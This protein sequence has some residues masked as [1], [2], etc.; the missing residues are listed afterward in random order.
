M[1]LV[2]KGLTTTDSLLYSLL[3]D[4]KKIGVS[5]LRLVMAV[6]P[7]LAVGLSELTT[8][9]FTVLAHLG[10]FVFHLRV[11]FGFG[12]NILESH[13]GRYLAN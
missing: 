13:H 10:L 4:Q 6:K 9:F 3:T 2:S 1:S 11:T 8:V 7:V 12:S 5:P